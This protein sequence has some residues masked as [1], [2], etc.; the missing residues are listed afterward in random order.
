[1]KKIMFND[2]YGLT[3]AVLKGR[4]TQ[5]RRIITTDIYNLI[6]FKAYFDG[7]VDCAGEFENGWVDWRWV[8]P[9]RLGEEIAIAMSYEDVFASTD[10]A[11]DKWIEMVEQAHGGK[12]YCLIAGTDN[13][14][15][16]KAELMP[17]RIKITDMWMQHI[18]DISDEDCLQEGVVQ[19]VTC[20]YCVIGPARLFG[21]RQF[22]TPRE[23]F[24]ALFDKVT[25]RG[26][27]DSNPMVVA[28][29]Y[30]LIRVF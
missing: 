28:Y 4:K 6:D 16:V 12:D 7:E 14:M 5:T 30:E 21:G 15:F 17:Y 27:F 24:A 9:Y 26:T 3:D 20:G 8:M 11:V 19:C 22:A 18:Q 29:K 23:A 13:K 10:I 1:M 2:K 25:R